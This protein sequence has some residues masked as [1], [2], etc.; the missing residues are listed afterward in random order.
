MAATAT[1]EAVETTVLKSLTELGADEAAL[2]RD[3]EFEALDIDSLDLAEL[4]QIVEEEFGV[5]LKGPDVAELKTVGQ[6]IDLIV[7]KAA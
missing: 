3:A 4:A 7:A 2:A 1:P 6:V 5:V